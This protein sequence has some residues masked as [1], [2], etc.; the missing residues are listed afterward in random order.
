MFPLD[1]IADAHRYMESNA[2]IGKIVV[3]V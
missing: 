2:Q 1:Q 3:E